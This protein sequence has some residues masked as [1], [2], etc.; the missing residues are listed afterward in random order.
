MLEFGCGVDIRGFHNRTV[1]HFA[2]DGGSIML[3]ESLI[4]EFGCDPL[5]EDSEKMLPLYIAAAA[6]HANL[7]KALVSIYDSPV[8]S[9]STEG[10]TWLQ[11]MLF[12][13]LCQI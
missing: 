12:D 7:V 10:H 9:C 4:G 13:F 1:L 6:G 2:C 8:D 3:I 5:V 11:C